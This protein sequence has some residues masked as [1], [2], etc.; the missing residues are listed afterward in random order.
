[1]TVVVSIFARGYRW[2][3]PARQAVAC[4]CA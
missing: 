2:S 4:S 1:M 3:R